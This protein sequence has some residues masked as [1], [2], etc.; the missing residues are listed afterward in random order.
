VKILTKIVEAAVAAGMVVQYQAD[1]SVYQG[2]PEG[3]K[4]KLSGYT[5]PA[6]NT[7]QV[8]AT[9][10][11][12]S[13]PPPVITVKVEEIEAIVQD[14]RLFTPALKLREILTLC[15]QKRAEVA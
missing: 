1:D 3:L 9:V 15:E 5:N 7:Q 13:L 11:I 6:Q 4:A 8:A 10:P 12:N 14:R 2:L